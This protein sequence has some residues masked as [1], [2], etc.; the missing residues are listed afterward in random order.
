[1]KIK[2][3]HATFGNLY[4]KTLILNEGMNI[5]CGS[6]ESG[7]S[8]WS[9]FLRVMLYGISTREKSKQGFL[10]DKEKYAPWSGAPMYGKIEF[11]WEGRSCILERTASK[12]GILQKA[13]IRDAETG[14][15]ILIP[16]PVGE[17]LIGVKREVFERSA[18]IGQSQIII[19]GDKDGELERR[20]TSLVSTGEE[21]VSYKLVI[22]RLEKWQR[23]LE[24]HK[25]G[26]IPALEETIDKTRNEL[27]DQR[28]DA[29]QI[30]EAHHAMDE[31]KKRR[32]TYRKML[33]RWHIDKAREQLE[34][35]EKTKEEKRQCEEALMLAQKQCHYDKYTIDHIDQVN[36]E[37]KRKKLANVECIHALQMEQ[38]ILQGM[39]QIPEKVPPHALYAAVIG[40]IPFAAIV[41]INW[42]IALI[43]GV[44]VTCI[45]FVV[46]KNSF[47]RKF[48][49]KNRSDL[50]SK[51]IEYDAQKRHVEENNL[52]AEESKSA[53]LAAEKNLL[54]LLKRLDEAISPQD[55][56][57]YVS[58]ARE[59]IFAL[60][61][62]EREL[63][64][65]NEKLKAVQVGRDMEAI[66]S[67]AMKMPDITLSMQYTEDELQILNEQNERE[68]RGLELRCVALTER[69]SAR[70]ELITLE[71][72]VNEEEAALT[73]KR[74]DLKAIELA[75]ETLSEVQGE[76]ERQFAPA[77]EKKTSEVFATLT[78][79]R[80]ELVEIKNAQLEMSVAEHI[81][82]P[83]RNI[84]HLSQGTL[85][86]L[87]LAIRLA[88]CETI[89]PESAPIILD[90]AL[91]NF[92]E[93]RM[94]KALKYLEKLSYRRQV[95][96]FSCHKR[97]LEYYKDIMHI[98]KQIVD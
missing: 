50:S 2:R 37:Y 67:I 89:L 32:E 43:F 47:Y 87:Y 11:E 22:S 60:E 80:F 23:K 58:T 36:E 90:D 14:Q 57:K 44:I 40:L 91:V 73:Q 82:S 61:Q 72:M 85:D 94:E 27:F 93:S 64:A 48:N 21:D 98:H 88:L 38:A 56:E 54:T 79:G 19:S 69:M 25:K 83:S 51:A 41:F 20:I 42:I 3:M 18:F 76:I 13:E 49:I 52:E 68:L 33:D 5:L 95:L 59:K 70:N 96:L 15:I 28:Q 8:T 86:E 45:T 17:T 55:V 71:E 35:I 34:F 53:L 65:A 63:H 24:Y 92:D 39:V 97:E 9:A 74:V 29:A 62:A 6:N 10:A 4:E 77:L 46:L 81:A 78:G 30:T 31:C 7:K 1:M 12:A 84:L 75:I 66:S 16:E 26:E